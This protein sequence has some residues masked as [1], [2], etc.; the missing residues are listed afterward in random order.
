M[1]V[2]TRLEL[3]PT[4]FKG[5][6]QEFFTDVGDVMVDLAF[7]IPV[8]KA[9]KINLC[10]NNGQISFET[11]SIQVHRNQENVAHS[12]WLKSGLSNNAPE[13]DA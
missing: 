2:N 1:Q 9:G 7:P 13:S 12:R 3:Q 11:E 4:V 10:L 5:A 8:W 6:G